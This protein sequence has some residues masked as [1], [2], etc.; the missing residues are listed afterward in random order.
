[1]MRFMVLGPLEITSPD[2]DCVSMAPRLRQVLALLVLHINRVVHMDL[3]M[4][5]LWGGS[6]PRAAVTTAQTYIHQL[7]KITAAE[8][9]AVTGS[10]GNLIAT[11]PSGYLLCADPAQVDSFAFQECVQQGRR[12]LASGDATEAARIF[13]KG[14][15]MWRGPALANVAAGEILAAHVVALEEQRLRALELRIEADL[16]LGRHRDLIGELR[17][18]VASHPMNEWFHGKLIAV[19]SHAG[20]RSDALQ[21]YQSLRAT[22]KGEL[23][24]EPSPELQ[25]LQREV[26]SASP[27]HRPAGPLQQLTGAW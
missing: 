12:S 7:R 24:L 19:L 1:M 27:P 9:P 17:S 2:R 18:L 21:A 16:R 11:R 25:R 20:R 3:L 4:E 22:L 26:L 23:G 13:R 6:P 10:M 5:E 8:W 15:D 14:L